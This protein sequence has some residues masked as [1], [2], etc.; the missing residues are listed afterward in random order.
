MS[1]RF[2]DSLY[3]HTNTLADTLLGNC[4]II[5]DE[6]IPA[7]NKKKEEEEEEQ[8]GDPRVLRF[9]SPIFGARDSLITS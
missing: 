7:I 9:L 2:V 6:S 1:A 3:I 5:D 4:F 8:E